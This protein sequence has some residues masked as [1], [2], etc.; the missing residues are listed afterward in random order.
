MI[1]LVAIDMDGTLLNSKSEITQRSAD[2]IKKYQE[3]G[4]KIV[5]NT[6]RGFPMA[7]KYLKNCNIVCDYICLSGAGVYDAKGN[8]LQKDTLS[9]GDIKKLRGLEKKY[10]LY[11]VYLTSMGSLSSLN[12]EKA[13]NHYMKESYDIARITGKIITEEEAEARFIHILDYIQYGQDI[14]KL[15]LEGVD[16][17]KLVILS[18]DEM[19]LG[20]ARKELNGWPQ[21]TVSSSF[22]TNIEVN[23]SRVDKGSALIEYA[24]QR[25][26]SVEEIMV[27]GDSENDEPMFEKPFGKRVAMGNA[28]E[29]IVGMSTHT[30]LSND[31]DGVAYA[32]E[33]WAL[34]E[35]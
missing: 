25:G 13:R 29:D 11:V 31:E 20:E 14:E 24:K 17:Y 27:I 21:L 34:D 10:G 32:I 9:S 2:V 30:T 28:T 8:C 12:R 16:F 22:G 6:G 33:R 4:G 18:M 35:L 19:T 3:K 7:S 5:V 26:I 1:K 23:S 15:V